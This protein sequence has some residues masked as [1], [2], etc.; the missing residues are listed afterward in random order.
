MAESARIYRALLIGNSEFPDDPQGL[1]QL[2]GPTTDVRVLY[3]ALTDRA[4]GLHPRGAVKAVV[5][6]TSSQV[7]DALAEF[8]EHSFAHE[9]LFLYYSGHGRLDARNRLRLCTHD[10]TLDGLRTR[11]V[12]HEFINELIDDCAARS[13]VVVL[14]CCFSGVAAV[15]GADPATQLSGYGRFVMTSS[16]H[17]GLSSDAAN[18]HEPSPFTRHLAEGLRFGARGKDGYVSVNDVYTYAYE[19]TRAF[20]Q[21]PHM[22][23]EGGV[24]QVSLARRPVRAADGP[25]SK[26]R[27]SAPEAAAS[28]NALDI[29]PVFTDPQGNQTLLTT[30]SDFTGVLHVRLPQ[31][32]T[33]LTTHRDQLAGANGVSPA[34]AE[35]RSRAK[36]H[37]ADLRARVDGRE[38][39]E[40][41]SGTV[42]GAVRFALPDGAGTVTWSERQ[43]ADFG[44]AKA[45][46]YWPST[47]PS[48][49]PHP[50]WHGSGSG[51]EPE[52]RVYDDLA[53]AG[54]SAWSWLPLGAGAAA[55]SV[56]QWDLCMHLPGARVSQLTALGV[57]FIL[58]GLAFMAVFCVGQ[59]IGHIE[60]AVMFRRVRRLRNDPALPITPMLMVCRVEEVEKTVLTLDGSMRV[61]VE[62]PYAWIW[63][64]KAFVA[65]VQACKQDGDVSVHPEVKMPVLNAYLADFKARIGTPAPEMVEVIGHPLK[66]QWVAI[67]T[68]RGMIWPKGQAE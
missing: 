54:R 22:K 47:A 7:E 24:G 51:G 12:R 26:G 6:E 43:V 39:V 48:T 50:G 31:R 25:E 65:A 21:I 55:L 44:R 1:P 49:T 59:F 67:R 17:A 63:G 61:T 36:I 15:K 53:S 8:F 19:Q 13:I 66:G 35:L 41:Q 52:D 62:K 42:E 68:A 9:Q 32:K 58:C 23:A 28:A 40:I 34:T 4:T 10:T 20:G 38:P 18:A 29:R 46:G 16:S 14:D 33:V 60:T 45:V 2:K 11:S 27:T 37:H 5:N 56:A 64:E 30:E 3:E 57:M